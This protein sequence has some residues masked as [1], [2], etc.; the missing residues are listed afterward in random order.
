MSDSLQV[1]ECTEEV[2][3]PGRGPVASRELRE[4]QSS[5]LL[6]PKAREVYQ[7]KDCPGDS[8]GVYSWGGTCMCGMRFCEQWE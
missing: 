4:F 2:R 6:N 8:E 7:L 5:L 1:R 3:T